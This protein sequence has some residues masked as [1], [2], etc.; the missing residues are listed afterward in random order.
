VPERH[1]ADSERKLN[2]HVP[3]CDS[4]A[5]DK[6][7]RLGAPQAHLE[8]LNPRRHFS[9]GM[10]DAYFRRLLRA[11]SHE[12]R[13]KKSELRQSVFPP[14][15]KDR[16]L[17]IGASGEPSSLENVCRIPNHLW[18][19]KETNAGGSSFLRA[20][21]GLADA[22]IRR[23]PRG[24]LLQRRPQARRAWVDEAVVERRQ[25]RIFGDPTHSLPGNGRPPAR[26]S[27]RPR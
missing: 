25:M 17:N 26:R 11:C 14:R 19:N 23:L 24:G 27:S 12:W 22:D 6:E 4:P 5:S 16:V 15:G 20:S 18:V 7:L 2:T 13:P 10:S 9:L 21:A 3:C 1:Q 8:P